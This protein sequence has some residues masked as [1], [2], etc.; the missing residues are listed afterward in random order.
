M[1]LLEQIRDTGSVFERGSVTLTN[2]PP[3]SSTNSLGASYILLG[4]S[5]DAPCRVRLYSTSASV[6]IDAP[7]PSSSFDYSASVALS[8]DVGLTPGTQSIAF[9]PPIIAS[10]SHSLETWYNI[11]AAGPVNA[12]VSFYP[13]EY[14]T[15]SRKFFSFPSNTPI[16]TLAANATQSGNFSG[17]GQN[18]IPKS[19]LILAA[20]SNSESLRLRLYSKTLQE[21]SDAE[22]TRAFITQ[23]TSDSHLICDIIY[24]S[25]SYMY[26]M[27]PVLQAYNLQTY[28]SASNNVGYILEN[29]SASPQQ[30]IRVSMLVYPIE[31]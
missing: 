14:S 22:K 1:G 18:K 30:N 7:R 8:L 12:T 11:D 13:I 24:E 23:S 15:G 20:T 27:S 10:T 16:T 19:F 28:M 6:N 4:V 26:Y 5:A 21:V 9:N 3:S 31:D 25:A 2:T 17:S 29:L